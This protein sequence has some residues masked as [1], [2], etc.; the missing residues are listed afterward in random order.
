MRSRAPQPRRRLVR[1]IALTAI[2]VFPLSALSACTA[3]GS[4]GGGKASTTLTIAATAGPA[5]LDPTTSSN[6]VP[7]RLVPQPRLRRPDR[8]AAQRDGRARA[9]DHLEVL[10]RPHVVRDGPAL[11]RKVQ[12]RLTDDGA[13]RRGLAQALQE[14]RQLHRLAGQREHHH[15]HR[16]A[17][18]HAE[19][20]QARPA[21]SLRSRP[22]RHGRG[23]GG[24]RRAWPT[25][26][27]WGRAPTAPARTCSTRRTRSPTTSTSTSRTRTTGT[28]ARSTTTRSSSRSSPTAT[29]SSPP[30]GPARCR[31][32]RVRPRPH[33]AAKSAGLNIET[34]PSAMLGVYLA[35]IDGKVVPALKDVR[36]RQALN[37]A[38]NRQAIVKSL[39]GEY[40]TPTAQ[41][42]PKGVGGYVASLDGQLPLRPREGQAVARPGGLPQRLQLHACRAARGG[43]R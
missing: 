36:V 40:G 43:Q 37:Y 15:R 17:P 32:L 6:G 18:G 2:A 27:A 26:P 41:F 31:W 9:G 13:G 10:R 1:A 33:A 3:S 11:G 14:E 21:A 22:G 38:V 8:A 4:S 39:Y 5:S 42:V 19:A 23:R 16:P 28:R 12:R 25:R 29:R 24:A 35:D 20:E 34:A 30:C 7:Q